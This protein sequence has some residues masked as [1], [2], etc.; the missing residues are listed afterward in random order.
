[1]KMDSPDSTGSIAIQWPTKLEVWLESSGRQREREREKERASL[2]QGTRAKIVM[3][4][5]L[6]PFYR[7]QQSAAI[8]T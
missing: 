8:W 4:S 5:Q 3:I 2:Q 7:Y 1:M 6:N